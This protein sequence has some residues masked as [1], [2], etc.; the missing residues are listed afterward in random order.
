MSPTP[1]PIFLIKFTRPATALLFSCGSPMYAAIVAGM[2]IKPV[3]TDWM[4]RN[5]EA[6]VKLIC[7]TRSTI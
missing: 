5:Q 7:P 4:T 3:G 6:E 1:L 2:K